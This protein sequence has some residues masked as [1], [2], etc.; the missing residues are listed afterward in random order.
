MLLHPL[1]HDDIRVAEHKNTIPLPPQITQHIEL[2]VRY[3]DQETAQSFVNPLWIDMISY[4]TIN[5]GIPLGRSNCTIFNLC[6]KSA[7]GIGI[8]ITVNLSKSQLSESIQ[9]TLQIIIDQHT[10]QIKNNISNR[11]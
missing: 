9:T 3:V 8:Y 2:I 5:H 11:N 4:F 6:K 1:K 7:L 10:A